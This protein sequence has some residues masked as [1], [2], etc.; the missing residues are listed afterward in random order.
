MHTIVKESRSVV[1]Y[2]PRRRYGLKGVKGNLGSER[3]VHYL[4]VV[5]ILTS[6][7]SKVNKSNP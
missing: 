3:Y 7:M 6:C 5:M 1:A 4:I 2:G